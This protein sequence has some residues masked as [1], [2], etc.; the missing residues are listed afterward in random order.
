MFQFYLYFADW[1]GKFGYSLKNPI[2][3]LRKGINGLNPVVYKLPLDYNPFEKFTIFY[4]TGSEISGFK[5]E[6]KLAEYSKNREDFYHVKTTFPNDYKCGTEVYIGLTPE[7]II[8]FFESLKLVYKFEY[9]T[10]KPI[11]FVDENPRLRRKN[12]RINNAIINASRTII[13]PTELQKTIIKSGI[14]YFESDIDTD[15]EVKKSG[16]LVLPCGIGKTYISLFICEILKQN[17][18]KKNFNV[19]IGVPGIINRDQFVKSVK[20]IFPEKSNIC[21]NIGKFKPESEINVLV[22]CYASSYKVL[23]SGFGKFDLVISDEAHHIKLGSENKPVKVGKGKYSAF[24]LIPYTY[25]LF[26]TATPNK[27]CDITIIYRIG[28]SEAIDRKIITNYRIMIIDMPESERAK[29]S[30]L[31]MPGVVS[32]HCEISAYTTLIAIKENKVNRC[33]IVANKKSDADLINQYINILKTEFRIPVFNTALHSDMETGFIKRGISDFKEQK[34]SIIVS[35]NMFNEGIDLPECDGVVFADIMKSSV[36]IVQTACRANRKYTEN[37]EKIATYIIP[38]LSDKKKLRNA[39]YIIKSLTEIFEEDKNVS[40]K[41]EAY[42]INSDTRLRSESEPV[43]VST[44]SDIPI[45]EL[46]LNLDKKLMHRIRLIILEQT[47][48]R[49]RLFKFVKN[50]MKDFQM[51]KKIEI[52]TESKYNKIK[53]EFLDYIG[54]RSLDYKMDPEIVLEPE[55]YFAGQWTNWYDFLNID[56]S[57]YIKTV[58]EWRKLVNAE[59]GNKQLSE[60]VYKKLVKKYSLLPP[61]PEEYFRKIMKCKFVNLIDE[62]NTDHLLD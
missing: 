36:R 31:F 43:P 47:K 10:M 56:T 17:R 41:I 3:R 8:E 4:F 53:T 55:I 9:K 28:F 21:T 23:K 15:D 48:S 42:R 62:L 14:D 58:E 54:C 37:P 25:R 12:R 7:I 60:H 22:I 11:D 6:K 39:D 34:K 32:A 1:N 19:L 27:S 44:S 2:D 52:K 20:N 38:A 18:Y 35:V 50:V 46:S 61:D 59:I 51:D 33:L 26:L 49:D 16:M 13:K 24:G 40:D 45:T 5:I 30:H 29:I 57:G